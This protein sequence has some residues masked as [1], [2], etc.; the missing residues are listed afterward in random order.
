M[1]L[2]NTTSLRSSPGPGILA[3]DPKQVR[4][5]ELRDRFETDGFVGPIPIFTRAECRDILRL[6]EEA[7]PPVDWPKGHAVT[8]RIYYRLGMHHAILRHVCKLIGDDVMLWGASLLR[9]RPG[10]VHPWHTDVESSGGPD[11]FVSVWIGLANISERSSLQLI[12]RSHTFDR[13][14]QEEA[15]RRGM[16]RNDRETE[17]VAEWARAYDPLST[18]EKFDMS[19]GDALFFDGRL[20]HGSNNTNRRGV[21]IALVLQYAVPDRA[22]RIPDLSAFEW[23]FNSF[24]TPR[25]AC[26]MVHGSTHSSTN[27]LVPPPVPERGLRPQ[28]STFIKSLN[29]PLEEDTTTGW[30]PYP[31]F[32]GPTAC[33]KDLSCHVS[34]LSPDKSPH[35]PHAHDEEELLVVLTGE[36]ELVLV[37]SAQTERIE[38]VWPGKFAYYPAGQLHTL[39][40]ASRE[41]VTYLMFKWTSEYSGASGPPLSSTIFEYN[42]NGSDRGETHSVGTTLPEGTNGKKGSGFSPKPIFEGPTRYL[43]K[44]QAH[45]TTIQA[46]HGY[47]PHVD[48]YDVAILT[49]TGTIET[50]STRV[51]PGSVVFYSAGEPHD[52]KNIGAG[53]ATYL[54]FEFHGAHDAPRSTRLKKRL[55]RALIRPVSWA[56]KTGKAVLRRF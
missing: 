48:A 22:V 37:D 26:I 54:V 19:V 44:L 15:A 6:L 40:N 29:L 45:F 34:V 24:E 32:R 55:R 17:L 46:G 7:P 10:R 41:P 49:M 42:L 8:S 43:H 39:R 30:R 4:D 18:V 50:L 1:K 12:S 5:S 52:M 31:I 38:K 3:D 23:P 56:L 16:Q 14:V 20:W 33:L 53:P 47:P 25:P 35:P 27:R 21:R 36:A 13:T 11:G 9:R 28:A 2:P 51:E